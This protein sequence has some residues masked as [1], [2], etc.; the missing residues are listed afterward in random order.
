MYYIQESDKPVLI[1]KV[2]NLVEL[3][4]DK[5]I[6]PVC[7]KEIIDNKKG[8]IIVKKIKKILEKTIVR[9]LY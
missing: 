8:A 2:L 6:L 5:I 7:D 1:T 9:Q 4:G 3:V